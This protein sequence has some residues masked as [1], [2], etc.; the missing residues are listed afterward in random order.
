VQRAACIRRDDAR[1]RAR[2]SIR[3]PGGG[4]YD[5]TFDHEPSVRL[6]T[7]TKVPMNWEFDAL[8]TIRRRFVA[9]L[10]VISRRRL[11]IEVVDRHDSA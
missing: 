2:A 7:R 3:W 9:T 8:R 10:T 11:V 5:L 1:L 6:R 4:R